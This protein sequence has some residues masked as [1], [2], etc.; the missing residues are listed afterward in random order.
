MCKKKKK[1]SDNGLHNVRNAHWDTEQL[2]Y[3]SG[4]EMSIQ[5][6]K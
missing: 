1:E 4:K 5:P 6:N 3:H 2:I